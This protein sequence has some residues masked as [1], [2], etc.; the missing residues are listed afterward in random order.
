M[1]DLWIVVSAFSLA[2]GAIAGGLAAFQRGR[3]WDRVFVAVRATS[4]AALAVALVARVGTLGYWSPYDQELSVLGLALSMLIVHSVLA[5]LLRAETTGPFVELVGLGLVLVGAANL[6]IATP[7][8]ACPQWVVPSQIQWSFFLLG[9][10]SLLAAGCMGLTV[11]LARAMQSHGW[12]LHLAAPGDLYALL[13]RAAMLALVAI[14]SGLAVGLW[15]AWQTLGTLTSGDPRA[16]W[17]ALTALRTTMSLLA[18]QMDRHQRG[19]VVGLV[20]LA[21][22]NM[23][24]GWLFLVGVQD[25]LGF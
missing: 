4:V 7:L 15:W 16:E 20:V 10:G 11:A 18:G 12:T 1:T 13:L 9:G 25:L 17:M 8:L 22:S 5:W 19:W 6:P 14:S 21:T 2:V 3:A 24:F 23:L